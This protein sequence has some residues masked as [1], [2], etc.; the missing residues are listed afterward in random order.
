MK[1]SNEM[2]K[3]FPNFWNKKTFSECRLYVLSE[4]CFNEIIPLDLKM[5]LDRNFNIYLYFVIVK[6]CDKIRS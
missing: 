2:P 1:L 4:I 3:N 6:L 5:N